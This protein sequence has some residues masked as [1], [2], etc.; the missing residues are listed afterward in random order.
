MSFLGRGQMAPN[1]GN[2]FQMVLKEPCENS[3]L[4]LHLGL[5]LQAHEVAEFQGKQ[6]SP[7]FQKRDII[8]TRS[9]AI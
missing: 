8:F 6:N 4:K 7:F 5:E 2:M 3:N 9:R 1:F